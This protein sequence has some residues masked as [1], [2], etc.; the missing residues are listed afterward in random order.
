[1]KTTLMLVASLALAGPATGADQPWEKQADGVVVH[2]KGVNVRLRVSSDRIFRVT[3]WPAGAPEP[4][5]PSLSIVARWSAAPF[6]VAAE[7]AAAVVSTRRVRA[8]VALATG[9]VSFK[10]ASGRDLLSERADGGKAFKQVTAH[11]ET[12]YQV[13]QAFDTAADE[14][15]YGLGQH[16]DRLLDMRG[17]DIDLWQRNR[18]IVV[19]VLV[20]SRGWGLLWDNP[21][22]MKFGTPEDVVPVPPARLIDED[23]RPGGLTATY[24][25]DRDMKVAIGVP[26]PG[27]PAASAIPAAIAPRVL[28]VRWTGRLMPDSSGEH[29]LVS[30]RALNYVRLW[31][32]DELLIDYWSLFVRADETVRVPL[33]AKRSYRLKIEWRRGDANGPFDLQVD[34]PAPVAAHDPLVGVGRGHRL[35]LHSGHEP[36]RRDRGLSRGHGSGAAP[37]EVGLRLLAEPRAVQLAGRAARRGARVPQAALPARRDR[38][39]LALLAGRGMGLAH[40]RPHPLPRP[41]GDDRRGAPAE[42]AHPHLGLAQVLSGHCQLRRD[43]EGRLPLSSHPGHRDQGLARLRVHVLRRL[44][45][46]GSRSLLAADQGRDLLEGLRRLVA[47]RQRAQPRRRPLSRRAGDAH[48]A[49]RPRA[50]RAGHERLSPR[51]QRGRLQVTARSGPGSTRGHPRAL[52]LGRLAA[53]GF[54]RLVG[55]HHGPLGGAS[56]PDPGRPLLLA[57]RAFPTGATTSAASASTTRAGT[58]TRSTGS[59]SRAGSS[60]GPSPRSSGPTA[61]PRTASPG[62]T[63]A[64]IIPPSG[65]SRSSPSCATDS[66]PTST[67]WPRG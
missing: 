17:R 67:R 18:E 19:P 49:D 57:L 58:R 40:L 42:R 22:H 31:L 62:S 59:S 47:R 45:P 63:A 6:E 24:F 43:E 60:S 50:R 27:L 11:G 32:D 54:D 9:Q 13:S 52:G 53:H 29:A 46:Q 39:G 26:Q 3:S 64:R 8:R 25:S 55:R 44:Q 1:M 56:R 23:G 41:P 28:G 12:A 14:G 4:S 66:C 38:A 10:D 20:S 21:S 33:E 51:A 30:H 65:P 15:L 16:Q 48:R 2:A 7:P 61:R 5:T 34:A 36:R 35:H 37:A